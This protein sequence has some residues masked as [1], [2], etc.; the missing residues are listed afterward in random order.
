MTVERFEE[1]KDKIKALELK[2]ENAK[3]RMTMISEKWQRE[4]GFSTLEEAKDKLEQLKKEQEEKELK[5]QEK[6]KVLEES[7]DWD[8]IM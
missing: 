2:S 4:Y 8:S 3:G 5:R 7:Y 6:M 1:I